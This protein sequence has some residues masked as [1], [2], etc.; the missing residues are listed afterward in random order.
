[1]ENEKRNYLEV[2]DSLSEI[3][4]SKN[5]EEIE[6]AL[7]DLADIKEYLSGINTEIEGFEKREESQNETIINLRKANN[8]LMRQIAVTDEEKEKEKEEISRLGILNNIF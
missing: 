4:G 5:D 3:I 8:R 1:M 2:I 7:V 6:N